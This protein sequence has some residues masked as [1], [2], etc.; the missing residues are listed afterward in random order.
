M[1]TVILVMSICLAGCATQPEA[2]HSYRILVTN[3]D[4]IEAPGI[5]ALAAALK[6]L[7]EVVVAAPKVNQSGMAHAI[8]VLGKVPSV[9]PVMRDGALFG[10]AVE[11]TPTDSAYVGMMWPAPG[12]K[13]DV[14]V[15]GINFGTNVG[16]ASL[17]SGT[18]G[19]ALEGALNHVPSIAIS[20]D[21]RSKTYDVA[22]S[23]AA[24]V[25]ARVLAEG[26]PDGVFLNVNVPAGEIKGIRVAPMGGSYYI[27]DGWETLG[28][29]T[30]GSTGLRLRLKPN[31]SLPPGSDSAYYA[32]GWATIAPLQAN[33]G[34]TSSVDALA[35]RDWSLPEAPR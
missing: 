35:R 34:A 3:D 6:P 26:L 19:A 10:Y 4:G 9:T 16:D 12:K 25:V 5:A 8:S 32:E 33:W 23:V 22:A 11:G 24:T 28:A 18:V 1:K 15:S 31:T 20:Q 2:P 7:G 13:V 27:P 29:A 30:D 21:S 17:Y 14:V